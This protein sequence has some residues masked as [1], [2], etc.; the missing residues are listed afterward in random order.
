MTPAQMRK[1]DAEPREYFESMVEGMG[2]TERRRALEL[3]LIGLLLEGEC[4]SVEPMAGRL[5]D[6]AGQREAMR[7]RLQQC[8]AVADWSDAQMRCRLA[9]KREPQFR[10]DLRKRGLHSLVGVKGIHKA[11]PPGARPQRPGK[12][13][14]P[15]GPLRTRYE[16]E[17]VERWAIEKSALQFPREQ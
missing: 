9:L 8:V 16:A 6:E 13:A 15:R 11:W 5:V 12:G 4:K 1:L 2:R 14:G 7:Q 17:G 10:E 3:Y